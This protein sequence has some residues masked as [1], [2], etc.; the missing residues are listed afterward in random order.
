MTRLLSLAV[1][2]TVAAALTLAVPQESQAQSFGVSVDWRGGSFSYQQ[3]YP[4]YYSYPSYHGYSSYPGSYHRHDHY[5]RSY[6]YYS[7]YRDR[8]VI[9]HPESY[10]W[11]PGRGW[12]SHGHIHVPHHGHSHTRRY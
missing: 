1:L 9:V 10:H 5:P 7:P 8:G 4:S 11:T 12:H 3:G 2:G 6:D